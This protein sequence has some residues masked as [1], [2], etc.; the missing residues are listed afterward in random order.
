[1]VAIFQD[2]FSADYI[3]LGGGNSREIDP[4]PTGARGGGNDDAFA[5]GIRLWEEY[6]EP[7]EA[8]SPMTW[9][10]VT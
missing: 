3:L 4:L 10:V 8:R 1:V 7:H 9:R 5:G 6:V 2:A